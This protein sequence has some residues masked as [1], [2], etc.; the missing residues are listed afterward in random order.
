[1]LLLSSV[2]GGRKCGAVV[3]ERPLIISRF[4]FKSM[5]EAKP[6]PIREKGLKKGSD[7]ASFKLRSMLLR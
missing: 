1:M 6:N 7:F 3:T 2:A 4:V 5:G